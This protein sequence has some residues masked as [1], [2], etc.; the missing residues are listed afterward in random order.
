[1]SDERGNGHDPSPPG[2][3]PP[4]SPPPVSDLR[5][6]KLPPGSL[7]EPWEAVLAAAAIQYKLQ[8]LDG[9]WGMI[10]HA[11]D[12]E[13]AVAM[14]REVEAERPD[15]PERLEEPEA[16]AGTFGG[17]P[18]AAVW[19]AVAI[20]AGLRGGRSAWFDAGSA[21]AARVVAGEWW[22]AVT[23]LTLHAD[24]SHLLNNV[25]ATALLGTALGR[26]V[27]PGIATWAMLLAGIAGNAVNAWVH[28]AHH[29][30]V[31]ASTAV[32]GAIGTLAGLSAAQVGVRRRMRR[33][34]WVPIA[35][36]L[37]V[38]ALFGSAGDHTD[39]GAHLFGF[40]AG[41]VVGIVL[42]LLRTRL[43]GPRWQTALSVAGMLVFAV[44]WKVAFAP[45]G[46]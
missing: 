12:V 16:F 41:V 24:A 25:L 33:G 37:G 44:A 40:L 30:S 36:G 26:V 10:V 29:D 19:L 23:A 42:R 5:L 46:P 14:L 22:R 21:D 3:L 32:F 11:S 8:P 28:G 20:G 6:I 13:R 31:G 2:D 34:A 27:G 9:R 15:V 35:A 18:L 45:P 1:M 43:P 39:H 4:A 7:P 17:V 38:L